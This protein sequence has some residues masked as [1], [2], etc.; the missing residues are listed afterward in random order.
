MDAVIHILW[1]IGAASGKKETAFNSGAW[2]SSPK[3]SK[4]LADGIEREQRHDHPERCLGREERN[5]RRPEPVPVPERGFGVGQIL[6]DHLG[7]RA[8]ERRALGHSR[9]DLAGARRPAMR[10]PSQALGRR[11]VEYGPGANDGWRDDNA[12]R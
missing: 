9:E 6:T 10:R 2:S 11:A 12:V 8:L 4:N 1:I 5:P 3:T 7:K